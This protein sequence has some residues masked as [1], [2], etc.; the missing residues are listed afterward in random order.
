MTPSKK[1]DYI[2]TSHLC[3]AFFIIPK[4][5]TNNCEPFFRFFSLIIRKQNYRRSYY[6][7][8]K[9]I[10]STYGIG[11]G[12]HSAGRLSRRHNA[13]EHSRSGGWT[14]V[15]IPG[16]NKEKTG[17]IR[18]NGM[19]Y[20]M[21]LNLTP[22]NQNGYTGGARLPLGCE[23]TSLA[24]VLRNQF[25][26][27][28]TKN[29]LVDHFMPMQAL[30]W[31]GSRYTISVDPNYCF[32]GSTYHSREPDGNGYGVYAPVIA[33]S[34]YK[35]LRS[36]GQEK[37]YQIDLHTDYYTGSNTNKLKFDP[38]K[39]DLGS[40]NI[41]GGLTASQIRTE[42]DMGHNVIIWYNVSSPYVSKTVSLRKGGRYT[43]PGSGTY[44]F[45]WVAHQH[46]AVIT[47]YD[48][49][50]KRFKVANVYNSNT[51]NPVGT[52]YYISYSSF[53]SS[54]GSLG[55]QSVVVYKK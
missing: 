22:I 10:I 9:V 20:Y 3:G 11:N 47:G 55:R 29:Q 45:K 42:L 24:S 25:G 16:T 44:S 39:L 38:K 14:Q 37:N 18:T 48:N 19:H 12:S 15:Y 28:V 40:T 49:A 17:Y 30:S 43:A 35:Y 1:A 50:L 41:T 13:C 2:K 53:D 54:Y 7:H 31:N 46:T 51:L 5:F 36:Q 6:E 8:K 23:E 26:F 4:T 32:W 52:T 21:D 34:A 33:Q 27:N